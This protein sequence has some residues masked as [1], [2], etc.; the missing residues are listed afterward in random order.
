MESTEKT[1]PMNIDDVVET[2]NK[3]PKPRRGRWIW[4]G[5]LLVLIA[6]AIGGYL[7]LEKA[8]EL[9]LAEQEKNALNVATAQYQLGITDMENKLYE[10][11]QK[12]FEYVI[13]IM[14][15]FPGAQEKLTEVMVAQAQVATPTP[16]P[17]PTLV[18]TPDTRGE[19]ELFNHV[20]ES[21]RN[22]DWND[23]V[24]TLDAL[25]EMNI[26]YRTLDVDGLYY[27]SLRNRGVNRILVEGSLE[28]GI[29]D[30]A[31]A[32][33]FAP[34]DVEADNY[35]TW[36]RQYLNGASFWALDWPQVVSIFGQL[37]TYLPYLHDSSGMTTTERYR[38]G[39]I[40]WGDNLNIRE[41]Y[42]LAF[43]KYEMSLNVVN[44]EAVR[45]KADAAYNECHKDDEK[46]EEKPTP[47]ETVA[48]TE[49]ATQEPVPTEEPAPEP[50]ESPAE[51][52]PEPGG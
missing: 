1:Q 5:I 16:V 7:G 24:L 33:R 27:L 51:P 52:T 6:A 20:L 38:Q 21:M 47:Q 40:N 39:L 25:R 49:E 11:A 28:P 42:C 8:K 19:E 14:P 46:E 31:L 48:P 10:N 37:Y 44:D 34:L 23:A 45:T 2:E 18:P 36:A 17:T 22:E 32:E 13:Q 4:L 41:E 35:R 30:L 12:R 3:P 29:Y 26:D 50:T 9:R 15:N 43:E